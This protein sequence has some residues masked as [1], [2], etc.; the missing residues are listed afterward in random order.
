M[1][2]RLLTFASA[3]DAVGA[4]E[5]TLELDSKTLTVGELKAEL[6]VRY[7]ALGGLWSR[8]AVALDGEIAADDQEIS[9]G[10]E[11]ALLPPVSGGTSDAAVPAAPAEPDS[12]DPNSHE[13][14]VTEA[15]DTEA[16]HRSVASPTCGAVLLF[17]GDVRND[18][19]GRSVEK[20]TYYAYRSMAE[21]RIRSIIEDLEA[22]HSGLRLN[23]VHRIGPIE[24]GETSVV[25]AAASP[26]RE[27][28]YEASRTA[29]ERLKKEVPIWKREHYVDGE[30]RWREEES[31]A[32]PD[33]SAN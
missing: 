10:S 4:N 1:Q 29:L 20:I 18:F 15:I 6:E 23:L 13:A 5:V 11:V 9:D 7:P 33:A 19:K 14:L 26:H 31:L 12:A 32:Q 24:V 2:L 8:L 17:L 27:A 22:E 3:S 30:H 28:A 21:A 25:I 16:V